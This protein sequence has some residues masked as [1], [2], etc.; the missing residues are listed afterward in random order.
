M[1]GSA[2]GPAANVNLHAVAAEGDSAT[3]EERKALYDAVQRRQFVEDMIELK[4]TF[5]PGYVPRI[6]SS[7][8][9]PL[10]M[11]PQ[12]RFHSERK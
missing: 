6:R 11:S 9:V 7:S 10:M 4:G 8:K 2:V 3:R 1:A 12:I 5:F